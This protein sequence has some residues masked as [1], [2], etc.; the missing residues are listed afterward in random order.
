[1]IKGEYARKEKVEKRNHYVWLSCY[2]LMR[3]KENGYQNKNKKL[4]HEKL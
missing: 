4:Y 2:F 1:M 3:N